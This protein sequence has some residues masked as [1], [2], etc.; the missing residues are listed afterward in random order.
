[1]WR[2]EANPHLRV[3]PGDPVQKVNKTETPLL[4]LI[5]GGEATAEVGGTCIVELDL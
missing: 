5:V 1:M 2:R 3:Y 4:G